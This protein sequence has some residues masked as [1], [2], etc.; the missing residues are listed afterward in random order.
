[1]NATPQ[2]PAAPRRRLWPWVVGICL[3]PFLLLGIAVASV[4]TLDRDAVT[5]RKHVMAATDASWD[6]KVQFS[7]GRL[8]LGAVRQCLWFVPDKNVADAR[9][10]LKAVKH[11][12]VGVYERDGGDPARWSREELFAAT[13]Q[14]MRKRGWSRL[15]GVAD[16]GDTV[17]VYAPEELD[18][19]DPIDLCVAVVND[20]ELVVVSTAIDAGA[21]ARLIE[22][23]AGKDIRRSLHL[24]RF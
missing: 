7:I 20:R 9:L 13:D 5:L 15:V 16:H 23:K 1:M 11:V 6:A 3:T 14:A 10:A 18:A 2:A 4:L 12:S 17:L 19:G 21:L 24:A 8:T 22:Q